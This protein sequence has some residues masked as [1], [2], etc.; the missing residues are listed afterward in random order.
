MGAELLEST[1]PV[2]ALALFQRLLHSLQEVSSYSLS[3]CAHC[4]HSGFGLVLTSCGYAG[5]GGS[6]YRSH[7][8]FLVAIRL[9]SAIPSCATIPSRSLTA[10]D[11]GRDLYKYELSRR[12]PNRFLNHK[13]SMLKKFL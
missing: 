8:L 6:A 13:L 7:V 4:P 11:N 2:L 1:R 10:K 5:Q 9:F 12:F 3:L